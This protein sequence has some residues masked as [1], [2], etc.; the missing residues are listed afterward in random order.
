MLSAEEFAGPPDH[1]SQ[2]DTNQDGALT[3]EELADAL[4][5]RPGAENS[6][7]HHQGDEAAGQ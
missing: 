3:K 2:V 7:P 1:F 6:A 4:N 5:R